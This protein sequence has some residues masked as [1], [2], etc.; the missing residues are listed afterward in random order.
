VHLSPGSHNVTFVHPELG[1]RK[2]LVLVES[3]KS[4]TLSV[5]F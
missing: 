4:Q 3:G 1:K 5:K 2:L